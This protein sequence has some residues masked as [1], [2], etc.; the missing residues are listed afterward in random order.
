MTKKLRQKLKYLEN[1]KELLKWNK[2][3]FSSFLKGF[4]LSKIVL[5]PQSAPLKSWET[6]LRS[7]FPCN[8]SN[9]FSYIYNWKFPWQNVLPEINTTLKLGACFYIMWVECKP[10]LLEVTRLAKELLTEFKLYLQ[11]V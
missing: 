9:L 1:E 10:Y 6:F 2:K 8:H 11:I 4:Q 5:D 7:F 3:H